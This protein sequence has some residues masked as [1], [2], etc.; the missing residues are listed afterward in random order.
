MTVQTISVG[1]VRSGARACD[2]IRCFTRSALARPKFSD[3]IIGYP[4]DCA[5]RMQISRRHL[6]VRSLMRLP[7]GP[8]L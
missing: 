5:F 4:P 8:S 6:L 3:G 2:A 1:G 7:I